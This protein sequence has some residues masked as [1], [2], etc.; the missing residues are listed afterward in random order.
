MRDVIKEF[1]LVGCE[2][3]E[4]EPL[5]SHTTFRIGGYAD[6]FVKPFDRE[7]FCFCVR[8]L[9][10]RKIPFFILGRG[11]NTLFSDQ[12][13]RG[14]VISTEQL[15][16]FSFDGE[17]VFAETGVSLTKLAVEALKHSLSGFEE[18]FGIPGTIGGALRM[19]SGAFGREIGDLVEKVELFDGENRI[20]LSK[21]KL[22]FRYR[23]SLIAEQNLLVLSAYFKLKHSQIEIIKEKMRNYMRIRIE[24]QPLNYPS[25]GS[26]F[27][28]PANNIYVGKL[29]EDLKL[30]GLKH[31]DAMIS[32]KHGG[33]I[34]NTGNAKAED[35]I[36]LINFIKKKVFESYGLELETE[37]EIVE[38]SIPQFM[39]AQQS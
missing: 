13:F 2:V 34:V 10:K 12:G 36:F 33:F 9:K 30:K 11:S 7:M 19:N 5:S 3:I 38:D 39:E 1:M 17:T 18:L 8:E 37:I 28:R 15:N 32:D 35:V 16:D 27:R 20:W 24:K 29:V 21:E 23:K 25:A 22:C 26:V 14:I 31:S 6:F 4:N